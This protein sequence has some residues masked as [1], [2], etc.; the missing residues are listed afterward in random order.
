MLVMTV[1]AER[2]FA[3]AVPAGECL[4]WPRRNYL[5]G[6]YGQVQWKSKSRRA[7]RVAYELV[8]GPIPPGLVIM[9]L[10]D[11]PPCVNP[12][13][14]RAATQVENLADMR[15]KGRARDVGVPGPH[16]WAIKDSCKRGHPL[17]EGNIYRSGP[18]RCCR[19]CVLDRTAA[20]QGRVVV[21]RIACP[22][23]GRECEPGANWHKCAGTWGPAW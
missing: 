16:P 11:N 4:E 18:N 17:V 13:H 9:H 12:E 23:C 20:R 14:L 22:E 21:E 6:G 10:C 1:E 3:K 2:F 19:R 8:F 15:A 7:H 5:R